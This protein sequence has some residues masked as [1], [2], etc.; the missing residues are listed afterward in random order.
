MLG[1]H[2]EKTGEYLIELPI[3]ST[4]EKELVL[5][6]E[7]RFKDLARIKE[8]ESPEEIKENIMLIINRIEEDEGIL[9][10]K[11]QKEYLT[12]MSMSHIYGLG[13]F[14]ILLKDENIEE[15][16]VIGM[17][18][19]VY[20]YLQSSGWKA[21]NLYI[22]NLNFF[23]DL[24]NRMTSRI[25]RRITLQN[26]RID[27]VLKDG[28]R[29]HA[30]IPPIS[31]GELTIR[32]FKSNPISPSG[33]AKLNTINYRAMS[34]LSLIMQSDSS[35]IISGNTASGK[36]TTLNSLF[37][38]VPFNERILVI[39]ETPEVKLFHKHMVRI[40]ASKEMGIELEDL[41]YDSLRMRPDRIIVGEIRNKKEANALIDVLLA[42]QARG[43]Y[44]TFHA[45]S[46][47]EALQRLKSFGINEYDLNSID[48]IIVQKRIGKYE[49]NKIKEL[50]KITEIS[51]VEN[52]RAS[53]ALEYNLSKDSWK[54]NE[55]KLL[56]KIKKMTGKKKS[57]IKKLIDERE[58]SIK[59]MSSEFKEFF[60]VF[61]E[62]WFKGR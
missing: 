16:A 47:E 27:A 54:I 7:E 30:S 8:F 23:M 4:E 15:I 49:N 11:D 20:V 43:A 45:K 18:K 10:E 61:Q 60:E 57:E 5:K 12:K 14:D 9:I 39:E 1:W 46:G 24:I 52:S 36:T 34:Y 21:T 6:I 48:L 2:L 62:K 35:V 40:T 41:V 25:G 59:N 56:S 55:S 44:A 17:R 33:I 51:T 37:A 50:R 19:P 3:L 42:G 13:A 22:D 26:P 53:I 28:S 29:I 31:E 38:F 58:K 32:K